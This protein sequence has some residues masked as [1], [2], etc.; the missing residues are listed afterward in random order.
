ML[1]GLAGFITAFT[2]LQLAGDFIL[3]PDLVALLIQVSPSL[4]RIL[5][6]KL[7]SIAARQYIRET[8]YRGPDKTTDI[9][10]KAT[11]LF[12]ATMMAPRGDTGV[13]KH[14]NEFRRELESS[15]IG[16]EVL[17]PQGAP[18]SLQIA[19]AVLRRIVAVSNVSV[20]VLYTEIRLDQ[21]LLWCAMRRRL[22]GHGPWTVYAQCPRSALTAM[23]LR[24]MRSQTVVMVVHFNGSQGEEMANRGWIRRGGVIDRE[25]KRI[26]RQTLLGSDRIVYCSAFMRSLLTS[27]VS[28][29]AERPHMVIPN[30]VP[31]PSAP[32]G[33]PSGDIITIG[34]V[35]PRK[36]QQAILRILAEARKRGRIYKLTIVGRGELDRELRALASDLGI[37]AQVTFAG[38]VENASRLLHNHRIYVHAAKMESFG[39]VLIE[40]FSAG[41]P[42]LAP[43]VGGIPEILTDGAEGYLWDPN[44]A[45]DSA[46]RLISILDDEQRRHMMGATALAT[47][48]ARFRSDRVAR[49][50]Y[51]FV[52]G[53]NI[54]FRE[55][56]SSVYCFR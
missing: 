17:T 45:E 39:I 20:A 8:V 22:P 9:P 47:Y 3:S 4:P 19:A 36:N 52:T 15:G 53:D 27:R 6:R 12:V 49:Q 37:S 10:N 28:G 48:N 29:L 43:A 54:E 30:F 2:L 35:E 24:N 41:L 25:A 46:T 5:S 40:A 11:A 56:L 13:Q 32:D 31:P 16:T 38:Y 21:F 55:P 1:V 33:G 14:F 50:L 51:R 23:S 34:T 18:K 44:N 26:E 7:E 42:V